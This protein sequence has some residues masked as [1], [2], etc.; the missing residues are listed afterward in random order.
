VIET[1][2]VSPERAAEQIAA[3]PNMKVV[4]VRAPGER[5]AKSIEHSVH[6]PLQRLL[7]GVETMPKDTPLLV[8]CAGGYRS[9]IAASLLQRAG[10][11][12]VTELAGGLAAWEASGQAMKRH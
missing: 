1:T 4:D 7:E 6:I 9:S 10:F 3:N 12:N 11:T 2:R 8:H 5:A